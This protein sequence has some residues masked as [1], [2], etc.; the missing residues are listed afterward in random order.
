MK[1]LQRSFIA[2][3]FILVAAL[4]LAA[5]GTTTVYITRTGEKYHKESCSSLKKSKIPITLEEAIKQGYEPCK[6]CD[7]PTLDK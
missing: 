1:K 3:I 2:G 7:P 4:A 6:R 5:P